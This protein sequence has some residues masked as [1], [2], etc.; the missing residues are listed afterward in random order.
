MQLTRCRNATALGITV[1]L[2][3]VRVHVPARQLEMPPPL[4]LLARLASTRLRSMI[5]RIIRPG[6]CNCVRVRTHVHP[7]VRSVRVQQGQAGRGG[8]RCEA[9]G[10]RD[11]P[12]SRLRFPAPPLL[13]PLSS[14]ACLCACAANAS[15]AR[16][17]EEQVT[18]VAMPHY[19]EGAQSAPCP[20]SRERRSRCCRPRR[21]RIHALSGHTCQ[22]AVSALA[23]AASHEQDIRASTPST[24]TASDVL[25]EAM[26][27][28]SRSL[29]SLPPKHRQQ[30]L[31]MAAPPPGCAGIAPASL[32]R[33]PARGWLGRQC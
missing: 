2:Q 14:C 16:D 32:R 28:S 19:E 7:S 9:R 18:V 30:W 6:P 33:Y 20:L 13:P 11:S 5:M 24:L 17:L 8:R 15:T 31:P 23:R 1:L 25:V 21:R 12:A 26:R 22:R 27:V 3:L 29:L 10:C 4:A